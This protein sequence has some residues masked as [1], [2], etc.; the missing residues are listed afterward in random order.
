M[1]SI[2]YRF[3]RSTAKFVFIILFMFSAGVSAESFFDRIKNDINDAIKGNKPSDTGNT[4]Q[5]SVTD[6]F[7]NKKPK[8]QLKQKIS[9]I[10]KTANVRSGP[11]SKN[12]KIGVIPV[13]TQVKILS[14]TKQWHEVQAVVGG[15]SISGWVYAPLISVK[16]SGLKQA[17]VENNRIGS[18]G[19]TVKPDGSIISYA[20]YSKQFLPIKK[21]M[22]S[23][24]MQSVR[25]HFAAKDAEIKNKLENV[26]GY[27]EKIGL[28]GWL[29]RGTLGID[30]GD[31][32]QA[33]EG[34]TTA[35]KLL[36]ERQQESMAG[37]FF[38]KAA[39]FGTS[40]LSGN[41][42]QGSYSGEGYERVLMLNYKSIAYLLKGTRESRKAYNVT[43][44]A[45]DWQNIEKKA[46]DEMKRE[47]EEK[48]KQEND[49]H[50]KKG[51]D[52]AVGNVE[53]QLYK[54]YNAHNA[55]AERVPSAYVNPFGYYVAGMIQEYES[56]DDWSLR[57]NARISYKKALELNPTSEVLIKAVKDMKKR[58]TSSRTRLVHIVVANGFVPEKKML[59]YGLNVGKGEEPIP[60][61]MSIYEPDKTLV[62]RIEVQTAGGKRLATLSPVADVEAIC[63]R[64]QKDMEPFRKLRVGLAVAGSITTRSVTSGL[65]FLGKII[66]EKREEMASPDMRS[67]MSLP[68]TISAARLNLKKGISTLKIV[69]YDNRGRRL[70]SKKVKISKNSHDFIYAR[71][72]NKQL[73][74]HTPE[75][76]W[77]IAGS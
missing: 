30:S 19:M 72:I 49:E 20:G 70:A 66:G 73:M 77:M 11:G 50:Q 9:V 40:I 36:T 56:Y 41:E 61:K 4:V 18:D 34:F 69:S 5:Q 65:G 71:S 15:A 26:D 75:S 62:S 23:G 67:W 76:L 51:H 17:G 52:D 64:H 39:Y 28:L 14:S 43:R 22:K 31:Y 59:T 29:E 35:E 2:V 16:T 21:N 10:K 68:A 54:E 25:Q 47:A 55:V 63:L 44:R 12:P 33:L 60:L 1:G 38:K 53:D 45:I 7:T 37:G 58:Q 48:V 57:D 74:T 13:G 3:G 8:S 24:D 6:I 27:S 32:S 46:F 42:E